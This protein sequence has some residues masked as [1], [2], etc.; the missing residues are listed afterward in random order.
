MPIISV[1]I[2][3]YNVEKYLRDCLDSV[4]AQSFRDWECICVD[5]GSTDASSSILA[6]YEAK[7]PRFRVIRHEHTNA[8]ACRNVGMDVSAGDFLLF[9]DSD[10]VFSP[11]MFQRLF[12]TI[13]ST[14][15]DVATCRSLV[16]QDRTILPRFRRPRPWRFRKLIPT[17]ADSVNPFR[18]WYGWA[19]DKLFRRSHIERYGFRFQEIP[20]TND[21]RFVYSALATARKA[22]IVPDLL[23]AHRHRIGSVETTRGKNPLCVLKAVSSTHE[24]LTNAG[25][26]SAHPALCDHFRRWAGHMILWYLDTMGD[27]DG[28][29]ELLAAAPE[30]ILG[31]RLA[32]SSASSFGRDET[33]RQ[34]LARILE[35]S[36]SFKTV[37]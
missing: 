26:F 12:A 20:A 10:D 21:A 16:F 15:A 32:E 14:G 7:D 19:W 6:E 24:E 34:R 33:E 28:R 31:L 3:V 30:C 4:C 23:V 13:R 2:P 8:G 5:D 22:V 36:T 35:Q 18:L 9:L 17:P 27:E 25:A 37:L 1:I 11:R 29:R